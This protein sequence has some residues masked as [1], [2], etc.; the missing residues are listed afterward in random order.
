[1]RRRG[2]AYPRSCLFVRTAAAAAATAA[3]GHLQD[4]CVPCAPPV[5]PFAHIAQHTYL[6]PQRSPSARSARETGACGRGPHIDQPR[7][8]RCCRL[9]GRAQ[10][11]AARRWRGEG[12]GRWAERPPPRCP[13]HVRSAPP[14]PTIRWRYNT[15]SR[16]GRQRQAFEYWGAGRNPAWPDAGTPRRSHSAL[17]AIGTV[18][19]HILLMHDVD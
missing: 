19:F 1:M 2:C 15:R 4:L 5:L 12:L 3:S 6:G 13:P 11:V 18:P 7:T 9:G 8:P 16:C 10:D 14:C 17:C